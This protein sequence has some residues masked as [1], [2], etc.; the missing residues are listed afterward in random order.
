MHA[1]AVSSPLALLRLNSVFNHTLHSD[2]ALISSR[3][4]IYTVAW[5][6][7]AI[8]KPTQN[9]LP[10]QHFLG[11]LPSQS[12]DASLYDSGYHTSYMIDLLL[13]CLSFHTYIG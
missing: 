7:V 8:Y 6:K 3:Y 13:A 4:L 9:S 1:A 10:S 11:N 2:K 12:L 5:I